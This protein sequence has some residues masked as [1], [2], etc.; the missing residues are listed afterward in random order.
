MP[1]KRPS[2]HGLELGHP[3]VDDAYHAIL[4]DNNKDDDDDDDDLERALASIPTPCAK[5]NDSDANNPSGWDIRNRQDVLP[6]V[7][8]ASECSSRGDP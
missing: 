6:T 5:N 1:E 2:D 7:S 8:E 4:G 3:Q